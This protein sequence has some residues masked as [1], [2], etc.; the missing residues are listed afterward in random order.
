MARYLYALA[1]VLFAAVAASVTTDGPAPVCLW[2][3]ACHEQHNPSEHVILH[4]FPNGGNNTVSNAVAVRVLR[5]INSTVLA[6]IREFLFP[7]IYPQRTRAHHRYYRLFDHLG[8]RLASTSLIGELSRVY[9][10][11]KLERWIWPGNYVGYRVR[12]PLSL[13]V[14][15]LH[16]HYVELETVSLV[17]RVFRV[18]HLLSDLECDEITRVAQHNQMVKSYM[19][20]KTDNGDEIFYDES[21]T[22]KTLWLRDEWHPFIRAFH[23]RATEITRV[24]ERVLGH[25][26]EELQVIHYGQHEHYHSH[27]DVFDKKDFP[28]SPTIQAGVARLLTMLVYLNDVEE[29][30]ETIFP[31]GGGP[32]LNPYPLSETNTLPSADCSRGLKIKPQKG[33]AMLWYNLLADGHMAGE[34]DRSTL[35]AGCDVLRGEK[36]AANYWISNMD[37]LTTVAP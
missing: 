13:S 5:T 28:N 18:H 25:C 32:E 35:H 33:T 31:H 12:V 11:S 10:V 9:L 30:G 8:R 34:V 22:S 20:R 26:A 7:H 29:G 17:P 6:S 21:R 37:R 2:P 4:I 19:L 3:S 23:K 24:D 14:Q 27:I 16:S 1:T 36:W 15:P